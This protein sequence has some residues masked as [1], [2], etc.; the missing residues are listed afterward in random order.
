M[1]RAGLTALACAGGAAACGGVGGGGS[2]AG[3]GAGDGAP[4]DAAAGADSAAGGADSGAGPVADVHFIGRFDTSDPAGPRFAWPGSAIRARFDGSGLTVRLDD[5]GMNLFDVLVDGAA[6]PVLAPAAGAGDY[7]V[8]AGLAPGPH[9][10]AVVRRTESFFGPTQ[11]LGF[12]GATL[13]PTP[14]P[15]RLVEMVGDSITCGYG[16]LG[17][18]PT[19]GF[20]AADEAETHA[21]GALAC[22]ALGAANTAIAYSGKG[23][24]LN[25]GGDPV[26]PMPVLFERTFADD[27]ASTWAFSYTP[28][29]VV[30]NLGT[31]DFS[32]GDPGQPFVDAYVAFVAQIRTHYPAAWIIVAMSPMVS[33]AF[34]AGAMQRTILRTYLQDVVAAAAAAGDARVDYLEIAEQDA[35]DGYGCDYHP[36]AAT[37]AIMADAL[38]AA[39]QTLVGW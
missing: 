35:A 31:N 10:V 30:V 20:S 9:D 18:G 7:V 29:V 17:A 39:I 36:S 19:C 27:P 14:A 28:D 26:D 33:D 32:T 1:V 38:V 2:D 34:P 21:W 6:G 12:P 16:V 3:G 24:Y 4:A 22:A 15:A 23:V 11:F 25:N 5:G 8:A 13:V 37:A